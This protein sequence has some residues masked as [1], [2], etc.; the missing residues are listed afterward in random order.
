MAA[1]YLPGAFTSVYQRKH[2][3]IGLSGF[4]AEKPVLC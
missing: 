1:H 3:I 2:E 4:Y